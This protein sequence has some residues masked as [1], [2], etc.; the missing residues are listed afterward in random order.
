MADYLAENNVLL[1]SSYSSAY[2]YFSNLANKNSEFE[3]TLKA[4][5]DEQLNTAE[6]TDDKQNK[7]N[8]YTRIVS[9]SV[10]T[11]E[12]KTT[13]EGGR[14]AFSYQ[15]IVEKFEIRIEVNGD[16]RKY[17]AIGTDKDGNAFEK[18]IDPYNVDPTDADFTEFAALCSYIRETEN[19]ADE[20]MKFVSSFEVD[21]IFEHMNYLST[22]SSELGNL[23]L[24][25]WDNLSL[26]GFLPQIN[27]LMEKL[28]GICSSYEFNINLDDVQDNVEAKE[29]QLVEN[30]ST[31]TQKAEAEND[32]II[33]RRGAIEEISEDSISK[34]RKVIGLTTFPISDD[35]SCM[36]IAFEPPESTADDPIVQLTMNNRMG[37][38]QTYNIHV[39]DVNP[40]N[41]TEMEI[42]AYLTYQG[43][44]G[45][46]IPGA[47]N[48]YAAYKSLKYQ[49]ELHE[50]NNIAEYGNRLFTSAQM[51]ATAIIKH[52]Y[53]WMKTINHPDAQKQAGWCEDL[54]AMLNPL[55]SEIPEEVYI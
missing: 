21:D 7:G 28:M 44:I 20:T 15:G 3:N 22:F 49:D 51:D 6:L 14:T 10:M 27:K 4:S 39:N 36:V 19:L 16:D 35:E 18:E 31:A 52:V 32:Y 54:L 40:N 13:T 17:T 55:E 41:A 48:N 5:S 12:M 47:I 11:S 2:L 37:E 24:A 29:E 45:N 30:I 25:G 26:E 42:F 53:S 9:A 8:S 50:N 34:D 1:Q 43:H 46:K 38:T 23:E 33:S